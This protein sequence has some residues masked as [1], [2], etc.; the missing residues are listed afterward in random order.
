VDVTAR[1]NTT[2]TDSTGH[3]E[4]RRFLEEDWTRWITEYP[5]IATTIGTPGHNDRWTDDSEVG[6][7]A[8]RDHL[9][10]SHVRLRTFDRASLSA[11]DQL[12]FDLYHSLLS[13]AEAG[14]RL[15]YDP[16]PFDFGEP[17]DLR[18]PMNQM[19]GIHVTAA[20]LLD[21]A[22]RERVSDYD[23]RLARLRSLPETIRQQ[24]SLMEAGR[25]AGFTPCR[26]AVAG[27]PDQVRNLL[28]DQPDESAL[29]AP[30][31]EL[32]PR[33]D[34]SERSRILQEARRA[35][36]DLVAPALKELHEYL[37]SRYLPA[38]REKVGVSALPGGSETYAYLVRRMTTTNL[39]PQ[40]IHEIGLRE[41][42][43]LRVEMDAVMV[44]SG[45]Q[46]SFSEFKEF[47]RKD[48]RFYM[49]RAEEL[50]DGYRVIAKK[51]DPQ[52]GR[53]FG[54]LPRLPYGVLPVPKFRET[55]SPAAYYMSGAPA[56][57]R[58]GYFYA[59]TYQVGIR[60]R[61]EMEG[62]ALH[63]AVPGHHL[64]IAIAQEL[65][66]LPEYRRWTGPTAF[67]EGWGLYAESLGEELGFYKDPYSKF[68]QLMF[69]VWR[70]TRL[71][72]DT[73]MHAMGWTRDRAIEF[74]RENTAMSDVGIA[75]EVDR[76][77]VWPGQAL[78]YKLGQLKF[79]ELR[80]LGEARLGER[81]DVRAFH[82]LLLDEGALP[83]HLVER[84]AKDW[85][86]ARAAA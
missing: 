77:I 3:S 68:G 18:M 25:T 30:F 6:I 56:T 35:Y 74:F 53:L 63:E 16:L 82:D 7:A 38:C 40:E 24:Q 9:A 1:S 55:S 20:D 52:L 70:S 4:F 57:G 46:G 47:L 12:D 23:D 5:E 72:V 71:V 43:R 65:D 32:P 31:L 67:I 26:V 33:F 10:T 27:L 58:A 41:V 69:D 34:P 79:R 13:N 73:G 11:R 61:W 22:P 21:M 78:A 42:R 48:P 85:I 81:F 84:R 49:S 44:R 8:R 60:P 51:T 2:L 76:Y 62:L 59:N 83:L 15:G 54:R 39:T 64:Q 50:L 66:H 37:V 45:F 14:V 19:E 86:D 80:T 17:H 75:V 36:S 28:R 29:L